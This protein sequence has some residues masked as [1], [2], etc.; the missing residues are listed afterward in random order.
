MGACPER[1]ISFKNYSVRIISSMIKSI[2]VPT[3]EDE[4]GPVPRILA[5]MCEND[6]YPSLDIA[7]RKKMLYSP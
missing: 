5:F 2:T 6:A 4:I 7:A 3:E 1:I